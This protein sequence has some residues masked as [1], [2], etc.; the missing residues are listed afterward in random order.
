[1]DDS[2]GSLHEKHVELLKSVVSTQ[3]ALIALMND[4]RDDDESHTPTFREIAEAE[5]DDYND[6]L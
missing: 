2:S 6:D 4:L 5:A 3:A 1:M